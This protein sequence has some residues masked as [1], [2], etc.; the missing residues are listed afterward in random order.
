MNS[1][2]RWHIP[3]LRLRTA[4]VDEEL[5]KVMKLLHQKR[6]ELLDKIPPGWHIKRCFNSIRLENCGDHAMRLVA[7]IEPDLPL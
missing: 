1:P 5:E 4:A 7:D 6:L 2:I 3:G